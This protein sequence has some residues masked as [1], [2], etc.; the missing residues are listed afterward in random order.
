MPRRRKIRVD[1]P[2]FTIRPDGKTSYERQGREK[3]LLCDRATMFGSPDNA[4]VYDPGPKQRVPKEGAWAMITRRLPNMERDMQKVIRV[5]RVFYVE[6]TGEADEFGFLP[7]GRYKVLCR[8][9]WGEVMLW[10]YEYSVMDAE[11]VISLWQDGELIFHPLNVQ[12]ARFN[13]IVFYARSRGIALPDA[14]VLALGTLK[15]PVG[16][17]E[18]PKE[19]A[20]EAEAM[21]Q[22]VHRRIPRRRS[23]KPMSVK[24]EVVK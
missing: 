19:L 24:L 20:R 23:K 7:D 9:P 15:G 1:E 17:F 4:L 11:T 16:W 18:P 13:D 22:S 12:L 6:H 10:P 2:H 21:E 5:A 3:E 8:S 14:M